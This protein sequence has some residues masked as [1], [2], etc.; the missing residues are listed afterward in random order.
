MYMCVSKDSIIQPTKNC[1]I[2]GGSGRTSIM[3]G[4]NLY[5][6]QYTHVWNYQMNPPGITNVY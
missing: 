2:K 1:L 6:V 4:L 5:K 3:E